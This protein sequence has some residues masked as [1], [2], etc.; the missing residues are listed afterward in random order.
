M[1]ACMYTYACRQSFRSTRVHQGEGKGEEVGEKKMGQLSFL[2]LVPAA[3]T[4]RVRT[5]CTTPE[6]LSCKLFCSPCYAIDVPTLRNVLY[7]FVLQ[8][9]VPCCTYGSSKSKPYY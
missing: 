6:N 5:Y 3:A 4:H 2:P 7:C 9:A 8:G 1:H